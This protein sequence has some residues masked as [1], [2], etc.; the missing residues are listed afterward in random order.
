MA[1]SLLRFRSAGGEVREFEVFA[2][3]E[4]RRA[5]YDGSYVSFVGPM[6]VRDPLSHE[7]YR[8]IDGVD[9]ED[10]SGERW[11]TEDGAA[12]VVPPSE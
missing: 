10:S 3:T 12:F 7:E 9:F 8:L 4:V 6:M 11:R 5:R 1:T 2:N